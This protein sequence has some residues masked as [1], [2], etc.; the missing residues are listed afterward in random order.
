MHSGEATAVLATFQDAEFFTPAT[1][2]RYRR[3]AEHAAFVGVLGR[4]MPLAP[5]PGIRGGQ[6]S[7][8]DPVLSE[9]DIAVIGPHFASCL[10]AR[11]LG[12]G[13]PD[14]QRRFEF[15]LS[16][17]RELAIEVATALLS[18]ISPKA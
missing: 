6:L 11:D 4:G 15:V 9:W 13:G 1:R 14:G 18:R 16:H 8:A 2:R 3:I 7:P 5:M 10:T 12:D 17:R